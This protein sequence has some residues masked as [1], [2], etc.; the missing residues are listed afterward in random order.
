MLNKQSATSARAKTL[1]ADLNPEWKKKEI[2][3]E[4]SKCQNDI[5]FGKE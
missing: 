5:G 4:L 2:D 1:E 3:G